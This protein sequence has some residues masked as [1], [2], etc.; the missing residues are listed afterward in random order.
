[1]ENNLCD[2]CN[3]RKPFEHRCHGKACDCDNLTCLEKQGKITPE[4]HSQLVKDFFD[5]QNGKKY[6]FP[7][8]IEPDPQGDHRVVGQNGPVPLPLF[9]GAK[10]ECEAWQEENCK[11]N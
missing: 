7:T 4:E 11:T 8:I 3:V 5:V 2:G 1:M 10:D 6:K 9:W